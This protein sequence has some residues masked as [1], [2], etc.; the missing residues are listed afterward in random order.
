MDEN[1][2]DTLNEY[3]NLV[4][5]FQDKS[6][7]A[8]TKTY[9]DI[10]KPAASE[11]RKRGINNALATTFDINVATAHSVTM[12]VLE[13]G[14]AFRVYSNGR[15]TAFN[16]DATTADGVVAHAVKLVNGGCVTLSDAA[17]ARAFTESADAKAGRAY[18]VF[19]TDSTALR[20]AMQPI[21]MSISPLACAVSSSADVAS[22]LGVKLAEPTAVDA[23]KAGLNAAL[24]AVIALGPAGSRAIM[25]AAS[26]KRAAAESGMEVARFAFERT[27]PHAAEWDSAGFSWTH[28]RRAGEYNIVLV[29]D[30]SKHAA[31]IAA[32]RDG[33]SKFRAQSAEADNEGDASAAAAARMATW[34]V[35]VPAS[36]KVAW[37]S[38][39]VDESEMPK[40]LATT[41]N[42]KVV[43][44]AQSGEL[45]A[46]GVLDFS[47]KV[48]DADSSLAFEPRP[49]MSA[50]KV[51][52]EK[53]VADPNPLIRDLTGRDFYRNVITGIGKDRDVLVEMYAPWC[54]HCA[55]LKEPYERIAKFFQH[56]PSVVIARMDATSNEA[57]GFMAH[58]TG[59]PTI[60]LFRA[61]SKDDPVKHKLVKPMFESIL[62][63][64]KQEA[65]IGFDIDGV[66]FGRGLSRVDIQIGKGEGLSDDEFDEL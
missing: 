24:T 58:I 40:V 14:G 55:R 62:N 42:G 60:L 9:T 46:A 23:S 37:D 28:F 12:R 4:I 61:H 2:D 6:V 8:S 53:A 56:A 35:V 29:A 18:V 50:R 51:E 41:G 44:Y 20:T 33:A 66:P 39:Y 10:L 49:R 57:P 54:G 34:H 63:F 1:F 64:V 36:S 38:F 48:A 19:G 17:G 30:S 27:R 45:T 13:R 59:Y 21:A 15:A 5:M 22:E 31:A 47:L 26:L 43:H 25:G 65:H 16:G 11:L 3:P 7:D 52:L 32:F